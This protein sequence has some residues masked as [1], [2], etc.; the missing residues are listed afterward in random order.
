MARNGKKLIWWHIQYAM[1]F[2]DEADFRHFECWVQA[3]TVF[4]A[5]LKGYEQLHQ[6]LILHSGRIIDLQVNVRE[7]K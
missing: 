6:R 2:E 3:Q 7:K 5:H 4:T 1:M